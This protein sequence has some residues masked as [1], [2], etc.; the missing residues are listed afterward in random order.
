[1]WLCP[2]ATDWGGLLKLLEWR[3]SVSFLSAARL[4]LHSSN[5]SWQQSPHHYWFPFL[6]YLEIHGSHARRR[7]CNKVRL[8]HFITQHYWNAKKEKE[9][10]W[11]QTCFRKT[12]TPMAKINKHH[13]DTHTHTQQVIPAIF[14]TSSKYSHSLCTKDNRSHRRVQRSWINDVNVDPFRQH[15]SHWS[16]SKH[17]SWFS[18]MNPDPRCPLVVQRRW[19]KWIQMWFSCYFIVKTHLLSNLCFM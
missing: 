1:M 7:H 18:S 15:P 13:H 14:M 4:L 10:V 6:L 17:P 12:K 16:L 11:E 5:T 2:F 8:P 3:A 19:K 9:R